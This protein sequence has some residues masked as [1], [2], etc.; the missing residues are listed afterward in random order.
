MDSEQ[1]SKEATSKFEVA[2]LLSCSL[3]YEEISAGGVSTH[4]LDLALERLVI[5]VNAQGFV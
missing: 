3:I 4:E 5:R 2:S 1:E